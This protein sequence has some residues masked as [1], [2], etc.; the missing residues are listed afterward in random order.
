MAKGCYLM[1]DRSTLRFK[2]YTLNVFEAL[3]LMKIHQEMLEAALLS[4]LLERL[5]EHQEIFDMGLPNLP[6]QVLMTHT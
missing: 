1:I 3:Q 2:P 6:F 4:M 5:K